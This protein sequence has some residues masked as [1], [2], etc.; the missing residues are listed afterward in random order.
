MAKK[1]GA[2]EG[3]IYQATDGRWRAAITVGYKGNKNG[4]VT[5]VRKTLSGRT[6][7]DVAE[8]MTKALHN[9]Q[10]GTNILP[11]RLS[12]GVY[13]HRWLSDTV[14]PSCSFKTHRTYRDLVEQ[15]IEPALGRV[16]LVNLTTPQIQRFLNEKHGAG[17]KPKTVKHIRDCLR[18]ALNV[19]VN[20]WEIITR[21]PAKRAKPP[22]PEKAELQVFDLTQARRFLDLVAGHRLE[23]LFSLALCLG[24]RQG[25]VLGLQWS[26]LNLVRRELTINGALKRV[27][28]KLVKGKT[29]RDPSNRTIALPAVTI[30]ALCRHQEIQNRERQWAG[31]RWKETGGYVF[32][33]R[34]GTPIERRNL[35]RDWYRIM[36]GSGLPKIRFHD[37]R[38]S[39]ATLLFAQGVHPKTVMEILGHSDLNTT[40]KIYGHVLDQMK[41]E[42]ASKM[43]D[44][45]GVA[46]RQATEP[47][48]AAPVN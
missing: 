42:A 1:R 17:L 29:K 44:L 37:L 5:Q 8:Q 30:A 27:E 12:L 45:F 31:Q 4:G 28:G 18:A 2:G 43:D 47:V 24:P 21:N 20:D 22:D 6:R 25:E 23:A 35:L 34:I 3:S 46:T 16:L 36:A 19:A 14:K 13:L 40:M 41:R 15:H 33:T 11:E 38:H 48:S 10:Q 32:T 39:A 7:A 26:N 9:Q